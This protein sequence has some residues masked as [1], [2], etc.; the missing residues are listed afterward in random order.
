MRTTWLLL[1]LFVLPVPVL[2]AQVG[3]LVEMRDWT[4]DDGKTIRAELTGYDGSNAGLRLEDGRRVSVP[5]ARFSKPDQAE[6]V[7]AFVN[8]QTWSNF[9]P[10]YIHRY[11]FSQ[12]TSEND[13]DEGIT[14]T[15]RLGKD[16][17]DFAIRIHETQID[18][19]DYNQIVLSDGSSPEYRFEF[20]DKNVAS[21]GPPGKKTFRISPSIALKSGKPMISVLQSGLESGKLTIEAR[22]NG[23]DPYPIEISEDEMEALSELFAVFEKVLPLVEAGV[24]K[25]DLLENQTFGDE[26]TASAGG[27]MESDDPE[28]ER[29]RSSRGGGRFGKLT[30]T[31][32][33]GEPER[34]DGLG[35]I[36]SRVVVRT[37]EGEVVKVPFAEIEGAKQQEI[38]DAR[39]DDLAG[40]NL[41]TDAGWI[42]YYPK[43]L[44]GNERIYRQGFAL[45]KG[46]NSGKFQPFLQTVTIAFEGA[47]ITSVKISADSLP[48][49]LVIPIENTRVV[50]DREKS[51]SIVSQSIDSIPLAK[52][53]QLADAKAVRLVAESG[54]EFVNF[55][56]EDDRLSSSLDAVAS[57]LWA[58]ELGR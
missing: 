19:T 41:V 31:P 57:Y 39:L 55:T 32:S 1:A 46:T 8:N 33:G 11:Y 2:K 37:T 15:L 9:S 16:A 10:P 17:F 34:V 45:R 51:W 27:N 5:D 42:Y 20:E 50:N 3:P 58:K 21:W 12:K 28:M 52:I 56:L 48:G 53:A 24:I 26:A 35:W 38:L 47:P 25:R 13:R 54:D 40:T 43:A 4:S 49:Q 23:V 14:P 44:Q 29:F 22:G 18:L 36:R 7:R 6:L 30:W